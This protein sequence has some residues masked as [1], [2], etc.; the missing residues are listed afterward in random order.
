MYGPALDLNPGFSRNELDARLFAK[1][2]T[3][4]VEQDESYRPILRGDVVTVEQRP[5]NHT[6]GIHRSTIDHHAAAGCQLCWNQPGHSSRG[7]IAWIVKCTRDRASYT[8]RIAG[9]RRAACQ[10]DEETAKTHQSILT[11]SMTGRPVCS[12]GAGATLV[13]EPS[14]AT[15]AKVSMFDG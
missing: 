2:K 11:R 13:A 3:T 5:A 12:R 4:F 8:N 6:C 15:H 9:S 1:Q 14:P 7:I 10:Q